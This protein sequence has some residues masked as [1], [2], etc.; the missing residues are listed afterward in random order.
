M[1]NQKT[2][3]FQEQDFLYPPN[4]KL[5][6]AIRELYYDILSEADYYIG[7]YCYHFIMG[8]ESG[9]NV[10]IEAIDRKDAET[11]HWQLVC[12]FEHFET[13]MDLITKFKILNDGRTFLEYTCDECGEP[14]ILVPPQPENYREGSK[15][16]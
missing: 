4:S 7:D 1:K 5:D 13:R 3:E 11:V 12:P 8:D 2:N 16:N 10:Y 15:Y 14:R 9:W 6:E